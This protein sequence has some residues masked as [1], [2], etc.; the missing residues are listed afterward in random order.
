MLSRSTRPYVSVAHPHLCAQSRWTADQIAAGAIVIMGSEL[1]RQGEQGCLF[2]A[3]RL[4][5][6]CISRIGRVGFG[7]VL[8]VHPKTQN[9][10]HT[11]MHT[12]AP[13][14]PDKLGTQRTGSGQQQM[15]PPP[16]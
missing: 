14:Q 12:H 7:P 15:S 9:Q 3:L 1:G 8:S 16:K 6:C 2:S 11:H 4:H 10:G 13:A 5:L